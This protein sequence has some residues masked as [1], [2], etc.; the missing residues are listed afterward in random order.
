[1]SRTKFKCHVDFNLDVSIFLCQHADAPGILPSVQRMT[2]SSLGLFIQTIWRLKPSMQPLMAMPHYYS[3]CPE[4]LLA[5]RGTE[6]AHV[7]IKV[8]MFQLY[9]RH[10]KFKR[11]VEI[12][13]DMAKIFFFFTCGPNTP[14]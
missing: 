10:F 4:R 11:R 9:S 14:S 6:N 5:Y 3:G 8:D 7:E 12:K 13:I 1:M 2:R